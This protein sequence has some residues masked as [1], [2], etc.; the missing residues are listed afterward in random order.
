MYVVL[1]AGGFIA[2][3]AQGS[4]F[5]YASEK[6]SRRSREQLFRSLL[7]QELSFFDHTRHS[8]GSLA[9]LLSSEV[10]SMTGLSGVVLG[11]IFTMLSTLIGGIV[12][13][14]ILAWRLALVCCATIP[15]ILFCGWARVKTLGVFGAK[16]KE[17]HVSSASCAAESSARGAYDCCVRA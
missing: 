8:T 5:A 14:N 6:L 4:C 16:M 17:A 10:T 11:S 3:L 7:R 13:S 2:W 1:A 9:N 15:I 12:L